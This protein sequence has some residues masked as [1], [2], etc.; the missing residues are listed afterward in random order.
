MAPTRTDLCGSQQPPTS[1]VPSCCFTAW[2]TVLPLDTMSR[3]VFM[4]K[5]KSRYVHW[6]LVIVLG[7]AL[8]GGAVAYA[9]M[10]RCW[11][12]YDCGCSPDG[13]SIQCCDAIAC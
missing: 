2:L 6:W 4:E 8:L 7:G 10:P 5:T 3:G 9:Q 12:C 11:D 13:S 1:H